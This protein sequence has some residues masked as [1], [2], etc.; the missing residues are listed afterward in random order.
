[1][2]Y[3]LANTELLQC[4]EYYTYT[5]DKDAAFQFEEG[6]C[7]FKAKIDVEV[8]EKGEKSTGASFDIDC[9]QFAAKIKMGNGVSFNMKTT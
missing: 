4:K 7:P 3:N 1:M 8:E 5:R 9:E 2:L 6:K